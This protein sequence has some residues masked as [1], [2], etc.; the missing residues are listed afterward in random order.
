M[1]Q[2]G[3]FQVISAPPLYKVR[4]FGLTFEYF[5]IQ[6]KEIKVATHTPLQKNKK[7]KGADLMINRGGCGYLMK[8]WIVI[9][10]C[11]VAMSLWGPVDKNAAMYLW[12]QL[13]VFL[14]SS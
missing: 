6:K 12:K 13:E 7:I 2:T 11:V 1:L 3:P 14:P 9:L 8:W 10:Q 5:L 4:A